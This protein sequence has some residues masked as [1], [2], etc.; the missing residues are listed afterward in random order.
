MFWEKPANNEDYIWRFKGNP[1][2]DLTKTDFWHICN[3]AV[4]IRNNKYIGVFRVEYKTGCP[5]L[6][7]GRSDDGYNFEFEDHKLKLENSDGTPFEYQ[8]AYDPRLIDLEGKLYCVFCADVEGPSIYIAEIDKDFTKGTVLQY[9]FL[10]FNRNGVLFPEKV[11]GKYLMLNRPSDDGNTPFG[12]IYLSESSDLLYWGNHKLLMKNFHLKNNFWERIKIG[13]GPAPIK[14]K[15]G[16]VLIYHG[17]QA[18]C[19]GYSYSFS[20][21]ILDLNDPSKVLYRADRYLLTAEEDYERVGFTSNVC[22]P[23]CALT[24]D[25]GHVTIYYGV[26]D[27]NIAVAFTTV[28]KLIEFAKKYS[29]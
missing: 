29:R 13:A 17:V 14:T 10:P 2:V 11:N 19:N 28:D 5:D 27:T 8:Y 1:I 4:V 20:V 9:G 3:S 12:H 6:V 16:W 21:A 23:T 25:E 22:F 24:D 26:T 18:T 15:E 7:I